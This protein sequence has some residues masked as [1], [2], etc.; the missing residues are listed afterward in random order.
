MKMLFTIM[1]L[2]IIIFTPVFGQ[3]KKTYFPIW[4]YHQENSNILGV[5]VGLGFL[6][7]SPKNTNTN[8]IKLN[9]DPAGVLF[10]LLPSSPVAQDKVEFDEIRRDTISE[11]VNGIAF[12]L[13]AGFC[14]KVNGFTFAPFVQVNRDVNGISIACMMN[15]TQLLNGFQF[16]IMMNETYQMN[17]LQVGGILQNEAHEMNGLQVGIRN[18]AADARGIQIGIFNKT[19]RLKGIQI[20]LWNVNEERKMPLINWSFKK[21]KTT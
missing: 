13:A 20:G 14:D 9:L 21:W 18:I 7:P 1:L 12:S 2:S 15:F 5:S 17:G 4:T 3:A 16:G 11:R 10:M 6:L 8:G 19:E